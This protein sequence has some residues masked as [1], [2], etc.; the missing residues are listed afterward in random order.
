MDFICKLPIELINLILQKFKDENTMVKVLAHVNNT[1]Y[2]IVSKYAQ[3]NNIERKF[4]CF[5]IA[6]SEY[7]RILKWIYS[8]EHM[9]YRHTWNEDLCAGLACNRNLKLLKWVRMKGCRWDSSTCAYAA[10]HGHLNVLKWAR[11]N[12]CEWDWRTC[13]YAAE[14]GHLEVLKWAHRNGCDW[15][16]LTCAS[17]AKGG[18]L[19]VLKWAYK[20]GCE[21][22]RLT[23]E[24]AAENGHLEVLVWARDNGCEWTKD[25]EELAKCKWPHIFLKN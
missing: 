23:C 8:N 17:A 11:L 9:W 6:E 18:H 21:W 1:F 24:Y 15:D 20:N 10:E 14:G 4:S 13:A 22:S 2:R 25:I 3:E 12:G 16:Y 19:E 5:D 7:S